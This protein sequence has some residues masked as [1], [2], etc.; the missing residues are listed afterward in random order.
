MSHSDRREFVRRL[1]GAGIAATVAP[2]ACSHGSKPAPAPAPAP[3]TGAGEATPETL[4]LRHF[5]GSSVEL[6]PRWAHVTSWKRATGDEM[7]F[8]DASTGAASDS[9]IAGGIPVSFHDATAVDPATGHRVARIVTWDLVEHGKSLS[10]AEYALLRCVDTLAAQAFMPQPFAATIR[11]T[12]DEGLSTALTLENT[13][14]NPFS[15]QCAMHTCHRV[16]DVARVT[17]DG[18]ERATYRDQ[19]ARG[20]ERR[21][22]RSVLR[23]DGPMDRLYTRRPDRVAIHDEARDVTVLVDRAGFADLMVWTAPTPD[24]PTDSASA[25]DAAPL[26]ML[27][28]GPAQIVPAVTIAPGQLWS[29]VQR[30]RIG[31]T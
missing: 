20:R 19:L 8:A 11:V 1:F 30:L 23:I 21:S 24:A 25:A 16:G 10:G 14:K 18:L 15:F 3:S 26:Q 29:G 9:A 4:V 7:L 27:G 12:L 13:G 5:S 31:E 22:R 17:I 28:V 2:L 6:R